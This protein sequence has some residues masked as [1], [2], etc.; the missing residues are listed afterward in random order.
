VT[1]EY[2]LPLAISASRNDD[3]VSAY[4]CLMPERKIGTRSS[5]YYPRSPE[6]NRSGAQE[7]GPSFK[8]TGPDINFGL[9]RFLQTGA[10]FPAS[11]LDPLNW[12][13]RLHPENRCGGDRI[14]WHSSTRRDGH[15]PG[16]EA[17]GHVRTPSSACASPALSTRRSSTRRDDHLPDDEAMGHARSRGLIPP[18]V[19]LLPSTRRSSTRGLGCCGTGRRWRAHERIC[20]GL[21]GA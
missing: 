15:L 16:D 1:G 21:T 14:T 17:M 6:T 10:Y 20:S 7:I 9:Q 4:G 13:H 19:R 2:V 5:V 12:G 3:S 8:F 11:G 18:H